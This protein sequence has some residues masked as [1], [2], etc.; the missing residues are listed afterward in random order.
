ML[1]E[2]QETYTEEH[3]KSSTE[4]DTRLKDAKSQKTDFEGQI[5]FA[6]KRMEIWEEY[7]KVITGV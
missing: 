7:R 2:V 6:E 1:Q 3:Y 4:L 5:S